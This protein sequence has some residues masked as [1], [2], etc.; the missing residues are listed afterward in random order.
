MSKSNDD[1]LS[2]LMNDKQLNVAMRLSMNERKDSQNQINIMLILRLIVVMII[3]ENDNTI[4][5][6][7]DA[8]DDVPLGQMFTLL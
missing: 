7:E 1:T 2:K 5:P 4:M 3:Q 6:L 8:N